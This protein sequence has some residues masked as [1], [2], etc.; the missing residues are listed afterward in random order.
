MKGA[1]KRGKRRMGRVKTDEET[2]EGGPSAGQ[3][4]SSRAQRLFKHSDGGQV[5]MCPDK[6]RGAATQPYFIAS[7][8][9]VL[10]FKSANYP[11]RIMNS[12]LAGRLPVSAS[13]TATEAAD[14]VRQEKRMERD[15]AV[16]GQNN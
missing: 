11:G 9:R 4:L 1:D 16:S 2:D 6:M 5:I 8:L 3:P 7:A 12:K 13:I 14:G 15:E 10:R